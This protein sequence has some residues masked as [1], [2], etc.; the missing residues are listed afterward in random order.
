M[1]AL[2]RQSNDIDV[3]SDQSNYVSELFGK[4]NCLH[5]T[6][7]NRASSLTKHIGVLSLP[8]A[9]L[10]PIDNCFI[11]SLVAETSIIEVS[12]DVVVEALLNLGGGTALYLGT[13]SERLF[14]YLNSN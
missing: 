13:D 5:Y 12:G 2:V 14:S 7:L 6:L 8:L 9:M 1:Q 11:W 3:E 10:S 4:Y